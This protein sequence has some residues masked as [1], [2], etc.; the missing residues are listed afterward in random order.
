MR[1]KAVAHLL[2]DLGVTKTHSRPHVSN[3][4]PF[5]ESQFKT[6]KY[7]QGFPE[8]F[9]SIQHARAFCSNFFAWYNSV[10]KHSGIALMTPEQVHYGLADDIFQKRTMVLSSAFKEHPKRF[11]GK[12]PKPLSL[13]KAVWINKPDDCQEKL[14]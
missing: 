6:L 11:K 9:G 3:D 7:N 13:P 2:A 10:H 4:N 14:L 8:R 12:Q 1:S 5:S